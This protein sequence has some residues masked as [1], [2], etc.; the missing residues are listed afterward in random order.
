MSRLRPTHQNI[1]PQGAPSLIFALWSLILSSVLCTGNRAICLGPVMS[2]HL[3]VGMYKSSRKYRYKNVIC[4]GGNR[5]R[6]SRT[7]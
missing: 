1:G 6:T 7:T 2:W 5:T 4:K 3:H